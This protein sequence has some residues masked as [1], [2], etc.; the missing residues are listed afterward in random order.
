MRNKKGNRTKRDYILFCLSDV[1][2]RHSC[3]LLHSR[4]NFPVIRSDSTVKRLINMF[5][6]IVTAKRNSDSLINNR[7]RSE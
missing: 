7:V 1:E 2:H 6:L 4:M 3:D 5:E